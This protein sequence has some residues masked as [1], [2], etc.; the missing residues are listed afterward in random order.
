MLYELLLSY[1]KMLQYL[2][3]SHDAGF[4]RDVNVHL[5]SAV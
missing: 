2:E 1:M 3:D 4:R 5:Y